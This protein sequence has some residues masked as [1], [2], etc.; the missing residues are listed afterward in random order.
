MIFNEF[1]IF[2]FFDFWNIQ[3]FKGYIHKIS[4]KS[5]FSKEIFHSYASIWTNRFIEASKTQ[6]KAASAFGKWAL[7]EK[8]ELYFQILKI[9]ELNHASKI[10]FVSALKSSRCHLTNVIPICVFWRK[11][12]K[13]HPLL[14]L[15]FRRIASKFSS[16]AK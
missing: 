14:F 9:Q 1:D 8:G 2:D 7:K 16:V 12:L 4:S 5:E 3:N 15:W 11:N 10:L 6:N 13:N